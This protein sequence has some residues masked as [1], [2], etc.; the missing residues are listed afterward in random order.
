MVLGILTA[1]LEARRKGSDAFKILK[2]N[3]FQSRTLK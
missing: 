3:Y 2:E 1:A